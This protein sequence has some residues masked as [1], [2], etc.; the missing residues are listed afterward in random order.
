MQYDFTSI[1]ERKGKDALAVD[2]LGLPGLPGAAKEGFDAIPM[3]VADMNFP[4]VPTV[5]E[6]IIARAQHPAY[7]Y[8]EPRQEYFDAI[9]RWQETHNGV[10]GLTSEHIG[11]ANGVVG[12]VVSALRSVAA[13]GDP[14]LIHS[15]T[16]IGFTHS[17]E[18]NGFRAV[19]S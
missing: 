18:D 6:A 2:A 4:T 15:P 7:G 14:V 1:M 8:F 9:I 13:P 3:W 10:T 11:Y 5:P 17:L 16:Y 19:H 12:G